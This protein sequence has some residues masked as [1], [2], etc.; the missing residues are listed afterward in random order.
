MPKPER[1]SQNLPGFLKRFRESPKP[2]KKSLFLK[3]FLK[4]LKF[5]SEASRNS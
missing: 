1:N 2:F 5:F 3:G 4:S